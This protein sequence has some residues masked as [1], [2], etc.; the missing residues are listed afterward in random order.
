VLAASLAPGASST[1][2]HT[3]AATSIKVTTGKPTEA[4]LA[5]SKTKSIPAG[6][7]VF[8]VKNSGALPHVFKI[9]SKPTLRASATSCAGKATPLLKPGKTAKLTVTL[10]K[11]YYEYLDTVTGQP[12]SNAK[13]LIGVVAPAGTVT[14]TP[15]TTQT[16]TPPPPTTTP[17]TT[18]AGTTTGC[19]IDGTAC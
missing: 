14:T 6:A 9:C 17:P 16:S 7:V 11:G 19:F 5:I 3:V 4:S 12:S 10:A 1:G 18:G 2:G 13:G 15:A 8:S